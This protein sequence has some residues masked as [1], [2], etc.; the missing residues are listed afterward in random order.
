[1]ECGSI[2]N[3]LYGSATYEA[4]ISAGNDT[5]I[6]YEVTAVILIAAAAI[7]HE[8]AI[9]VRFANSNS[10]YVLGLGCYGYKYCIFK[11]MHGVDTVLG[12]S[13]VIADVSHNVSYTLKAVCEGSTLELWEGGVKVLDTTDTDLTSGSIGLRTYNS[14]IEVSSM[15]AA[16]GSVGPGATA[17]EGFFMLNRRK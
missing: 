12:S 15:S 16:V 17:L 5:W 10:F 14:S 11:K 7:T 3:K 2:V 4:L 9:I 8:A 13:G 1:L 6:N